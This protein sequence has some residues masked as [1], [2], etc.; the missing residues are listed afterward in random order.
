MNFSLKLVSNTSNDVQNALSWT[1]QFIHNVLFELKK[2]LAS[3]IHG[4]KEYSINLQANI[5]NRHDLNM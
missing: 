5:P 2:K 3:K 4:T 1:Y